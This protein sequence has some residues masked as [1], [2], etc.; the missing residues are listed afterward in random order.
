[1]KR[2]LFVFLIGLQPLVARSKFLT[3]SIDDVV[4]RGEGTDA[5]II[6]QGRPPRTL[7][8]V[9]VPEAWNWMSNF[10]GMGGEAGEG[11]YGFSWP[12]GAAI[13]NF[14]LWNSY[15]VIGAK[16]K[17]LPYATIHDYVSPEWGPSVSP[18][19]SAAPGKSVYDVV[20][21]WDDFKSNPNN[22]SGRHLGVKV[23][24]RSLSWPHEP[25][26][27]FIAYEFY[28]IFFKDSCD[29]PGVGDQLDSVFIGMW[30]DCDVSGYDATNNH[31]DDL[32]GYMGWTNKEWDNP[33]FKYL[34][35]NMDM[36]THFSKD[37]FI[38]EPDG[39][40]DHY[41]IWGDEEDEKIVNPA[42]AIEIT[43]A[44]NTYTGYLIPYGMSYIYDGD[45]PMVPGDDTGEGGGS[46]GYMG[47]AFI[48]A[49]PSPSDSIFVDGG[50]TFRIVRPWGHQW[51][52]WESDPSIDRDVYAYLVGRHP[53]TA[54]YRYAPH[55]RDF[56]AKEFDYRFF[57]TAGPYTLKDRD[58]LKFVW[59]VP[60]GQGLHGGLDEKWNR[61]WQRGMLHNL[62]WAFKAYYSGDP[63]DPAHPTP[64]VF[65]PSKDTHWKI[66]VPPPTPLLKY[67]AA[68]GKVTLLWNAAAESYK[69]PLKG[70]PDF[71]GYILYRALF[72]PRD[73]DTLA[74]LVKQNGTIQRTFVDT[75]AKIGYPYYYVVTA[76][77][78]DT[79]ESAKTNYRKTPEGVPE[80]IVIPSVTSNELDKVYVVPN[81]F[82][83][84]AK[85]SATELHNKIE[86]RNLPG[87]CVIFIL[88][89]SGKLVK[90]IVH[91]SGT[92]SAYWD[93]LNENG[94]KVS[95]GV[96]YYKVVTPD[97]K[98][99]FGKFIILD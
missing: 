8:W 36:V 2:L 98:E 19:I 77:D 5:P 76:F 3:D 55:P 34:W 1:M 29:I 15:F 66:K 99:K 71:V 81:P 85:W 33:N 37:T 20:S 62:E 7:V 47:G 49:P 26:N 65:D 23:L 48:Y 74:V 32:V 22:S 75:T 35:D 11:W 93:L 92:G 41:F 43:Q 51:W 12:G 69:D 73:F 46:A 21:A 79:L 45:D 58:T 61:G 72:E 6:L 94:I 14:Y 78:E 27:D 84:S 38:P 95:S 82:K 90:K 88:T 39:I 17:G 80:P 50:D 52:N 97:G 28:I 42:H 10:G 83:G 86:F 68:P 60:V 64:P 24:V 89:F 16:V 53:A 96:Y 44:G 56:G 70:R 18:P 13:N 25:Y 63:G 31:I 9:T 87:S 4:I 67:T 59:V 91:S 30:Y 40:S 54:P 57:T